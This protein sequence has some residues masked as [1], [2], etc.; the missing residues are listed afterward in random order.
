MNNEHVVTSTV[1]FNACGEWIPTIILIH[2]DAF[3]LT[4]CTD[5][6][7]VLLIVESNAG[8]ITPWLL[9]IT[10]FEQINPLFR[11][12]IVTLFVSN[13]QVSNIPRTNIATTLHENVTIGRC[14]LIINS[15]FHPI[16][17]DGELSIR[18]LTKA[19]HRDIFGMVTLNLV[20]K[21]ID[22]T[23]LCIYTTDREELAKPTC[24][25]T[26]IVHGNF[27]ALEM[28]TTILD[29]KA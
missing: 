2:V 21:R 4:P 1:I 17:S 28:K 26:I 14:C 18:C 8:K 29:R 6:I 25:Y 20:V 13:L 3:L 23:Y 12:L 9:C 11:T 5:L 24:F 7:V 19:Q 27:C 22:S 10:I 15:T 16:G